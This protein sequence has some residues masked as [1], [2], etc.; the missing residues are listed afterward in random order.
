MQQYQKTCNG[1]TW[2]SRMHK[3]YLCWKFIFQ[4]QHFSYNGNKEGCRTHYTRKMALQD[5]AP[6][7]MVFIW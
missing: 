1:F 2:K 4:Q 5:V 6:Q 3:H 7:W